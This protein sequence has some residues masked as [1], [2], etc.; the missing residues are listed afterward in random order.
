[1][2]YKYLGHI[3]DT[4]YPEKPIVNARYCT[5]GIVMNAK[6]EIAL[7]HIVGKDDFGDRDHYELPGGGIEDHEGSKECFIREIQE[8]LG[9]HIDEPVPLGVMTYDFNLIQLHN[10]AIYFFAHVICEAP[11]HLTDQEKTL[12]NEIKW[13]PLDEAISFLETVPVKNVGILLHK[14]ALIA[15]KECSKLFTK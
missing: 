6:G 3:A 11:K 9:L 1:M 14:R 5:R 12:F 13:L 10:I 2:I 7:I 8:E 15:L 4:I